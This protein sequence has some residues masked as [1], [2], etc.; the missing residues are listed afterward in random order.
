[1]ENPG[2]I[3]YDQDIILAKPDQDSPQRQRGYAQVA[4]HELAHQWFGN[5]VT[6]AWWNDTWLN[7]AF[8]TWME[9]KLTAE[10]KPEWQTRV[11]E[12]EQRLFTMGRDSLVSAR[13]I[14]QPAGN[15]ERHRECF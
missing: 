12:Q 2:L 4:I 11:A 9:Q 5:L 8:A 13:R 10:W 6:M 3:T 14:N 1:M 7:E 15:E